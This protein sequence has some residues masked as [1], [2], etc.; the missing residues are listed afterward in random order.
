MKIIIGSTNASKLAAVN[1][2]FSK[3][4]LGEEFKCI[5]INVD[6]GISDHPTSARESIEGAINRVNATKDSYPGADYYIGMEGGLLNVNDHYWEI[7]WVA[8]LDVNGNLSTALS[9]GIELKG[10]LLKQIL[11]GVELSLALESTIGLKDVGKKNG[12]YG[13][14]T[15]DVL[16]RQQAYAQGVIFAIAQFKHPELFA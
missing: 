7:G 14:A 12:F 10:K 6:S 1:M 11:A 13:L 16:D 2:A 4:V 9:P 15:D 8:V 3:L 5:G